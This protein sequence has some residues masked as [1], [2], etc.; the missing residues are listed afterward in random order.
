ME[1]NDYDDAYRREVE[2]L[3]RKDAEKKARQDFKRLK[4][5]QKWA[6][7]KEEWAEVKEEWAEAK[8]EW[9]QDENNM[10]TNGIFSKKKQKPTKMTFVY[11]M[12]VLLVVLFFL[13]VAS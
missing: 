3:L 2:K 10:F 13:G 9:A 1:G 6:A 4:R 12:L 8:E 11:V 7:V 5:A